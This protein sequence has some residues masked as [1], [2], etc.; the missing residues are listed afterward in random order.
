MSIYTTKQLAS[1]LHLKVALL[2]D[3][4]QESN[5]HY[6]PYSKKKHREDGTIKERI[7]DNPDK[8]IKS[9]QRIINRIILSPAIR[10]LPPYMHGARP[11][12]NIRTS[13][14]VHIGQPALLT[15]DL[16]NCFPSINSGMVYNLFRA[17]FGY[18]KPIATILTRL[19]TY[20]GHLPQGSPT[21]SSLCNLILEPLVTELYN[22]C[23]SHGINFSQFMDDFY[24][25]G[26]LIA[27]L[28]IKQKAMSRI[29]DHHLKI[30][31]RK[32]RITT[33]ANGMILANITINRKI[34]IGHSKKH[35]LERTIMRLTK[36]D[37][38]DYKLKAHEVQIA[39][40]QHRKVP[41]CKT[42]IHTLKGQIAN[43]F[44]INPEQGHILHQKLNKR[45]N[46]LQ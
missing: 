23:T 38:A 30:S 3:L 31:Q 12:K 16:E 6:H 41:K 32:T 18:S 28:K 43:V 7:I 46:S 5:S 13:A 24:L 8:E 25:S 17:R 44:A 26:Q 36:N 20:Q 34:S 22:L 27:L 40:R 33:R 2:H 42:K 35:S 9:V 14:K 45:L 1:T 39:Q 10:S 37:L 4:A 11:G 21:S 15:L 29:T 19:T